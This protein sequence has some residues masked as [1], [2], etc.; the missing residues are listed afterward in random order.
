VRSKP[1]FRP[2]YQGILLLVLFLACVYCNANAQNIQVKSKLDKSTILIGDQTTLRLTAHIP[3]KSDITFPQLKDSIGKIKIVNG[4]KPE[5]TFDKNDPARETITHSYLI[6]SF[7]SGSYVIPALEFHTNAGSFKTGVVKLRVTSVP[8][9]TTKVFYDI[10]QPF[11]VPYTFWDWLRAHWVLVALVLFILLTVI[12][13]VY[14]LKSRPEIVIIKKTA[15]VLTIDAIALNK[16][17][18]LR[19]KKL[20]Q[21]DKVKLHYTELVDIL[22]EYLD[23]RYRIRTE[24]Q[25]TAEILSALK[26]KTMPESARNG[27]EQILY[28]ADLVKFAREKPSPAENEQKIEDAI[29]FIR[30]TREEPSA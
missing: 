8:V 20:W 30:Q 10:K 22:Q 26:E 2:N 14:Y 24:E 3:A 1:C 12:A 28:L 17:Y 23:K 29:E 19:D 18:A 6:T 7:D 13:I 5:I 16:L 11:V 15:P 4:L 27:L 21:Q 25:T 9:D